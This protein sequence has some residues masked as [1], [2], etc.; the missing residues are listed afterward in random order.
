M[1]GNVQQGS[2][3]WQSPPP[4][5]NPVITAAARRRQASL[6]K[7]LGSLGRLE[8]LAVTFAGWQDT[9]LPRL[10]Q[11]GICVFAADHGIAETGV[12]AFCA[13]AM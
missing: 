12:S 9:S 3:W 13:A 11:I 4:L 5:I 6:T 10:E 1:T 8:E 2:H 7:P